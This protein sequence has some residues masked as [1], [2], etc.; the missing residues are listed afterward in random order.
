MFIAFTHQFFEDSGPH[1][2][3][4]NMAG[5]DRV[6]IIETNFQ[7]PLTSLFYDPE[8]HRILFTDPTKGEISSVA[9]DGKNATD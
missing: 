9:V 5:G 4:L 3:R 8:L 1:I 6:H 2:D 7:G